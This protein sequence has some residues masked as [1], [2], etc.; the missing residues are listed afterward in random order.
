MSDDPLGAR[1]SCAET[2][3][4][5]AENVPPPEFL[6]AADEREEAAGHLALR[7]LYGLEIPELEP[8]PLRDLAV[9]HRLDALLGEQT[10]VPQAVR[11]DRALAFACRDDVAIEVGVLI[12]RNIIAADPSGMP[13]WQAR[14]H[15]GIRERDAS[16]Q[17]F[18][19]FGR[20]IG[21]ST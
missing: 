17:F 11:L 14:G 9:A 19:K 1:A 8:D 6:R 12:G 15:Q 18:A 7:I 3:A 10:P 21:S 20:F 4:Y 13:E 16:R 5:I 2:K